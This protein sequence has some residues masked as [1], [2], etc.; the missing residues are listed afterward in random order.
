[1]PRQKIK[2]MQNI[3]YNNMQDDTDDCICGCKPV[4]DGI[5]LII[6]SIED[7]FTV[8]MRYDVG[9]SDNE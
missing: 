8:I 4:V 9:I 6:K 3:K 2:H 7:A 5:R 1:M